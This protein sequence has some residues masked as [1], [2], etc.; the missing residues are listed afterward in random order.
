[1]IR[2]SHWVER[3]PWVIAISIFVILHSG[4]ILFS[5]LNR[6]IYGDEGHFIA[7]ITQ[8]AQNYSR[9][10]LRT[11][12]EMSTPLPFVLYAL[13]GKL[14]GLEAATLR[15]FSLLLGFAAALLFFAIA[16]Q[17][18]VQSRTIFFAYLLFL[19]QPYLIGFTMY[20][21]TDL[22]AIIGLLLALWE[23][24]K[25]NEW[26]LGIGCVIALLSR[27]YSVFFIAALMLFYIL[28][29]IWAK[30]P[31]SLR[32]LLVVIL[33]CLPLTFL[34]AYWQ[35][36]VPDNTM[37]TLYLD[38]ALS[39]HLSSAVL[40][41]SCITIYLF[42]V[43]LVRRKNVFLN[44]TVWLIAILMSSIYLLAPIRA[45]QAAANVDIET[46]GLFHR[47]LRYV[48]DNP[49]VINGIFYFCFLIGLVVFV[50]FLALFWKLRKE[51]AN[52]VDM[53]L[54]LSLVCFLLVMPFSYL[55][56]E[57]YFILLLPFLLLLLLK[58]SPIKKRR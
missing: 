38:T 55:H 29:Y 14:F 24:I 42:P 30:R 10:T 23:G 41:L 49:L 26:W 52:G 1:M 53:L 33:S 16:K 12:N 35:G 51:K 45:S 50:H 28:E 47:L 15:L 19:F 7:T 2:F 40:Y 37:R 4:I 22:F 31:A 27:Q 58:E 18:L 5:G 21:Y 39:Y 54:I 11:Y 46:V 8:F 44:K 48:F 32:T 9:E 6:P 57:K 43:L 25:R 36:I 56:W 20:V 13:W 17:L 3:Y 34:F